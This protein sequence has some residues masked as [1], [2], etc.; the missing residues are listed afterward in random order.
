VARDPHAS[1]KTGTMRSFLP[2]VVGLTC[3][4]LYAQTSHTIVA[5]DFQFAPDLLTI[6]AGDTVW[7]HLGAGHSFRE[8]TADAWDL[9]VTTPIIGYDIGPFTEY[10]EEH[11]LVITTAPDTLYYLCVPHAD[12]G[13]KGRIIIQEGNMGIQASSMEPAVLFPNPTEGPLSLVPPVPGTVQAVITDAAGRI[14]EVP[15]SR[16]GRLDVGELPSGSYQVS[17]IDADGVELTRRTI[18]VRH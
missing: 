12:M 8:V 4:G 17:F 3:S 16:D 11:Y 7:L 2:F 1:V 18:A 6:N 13:M 15:V 5:S 14:V 9:N 10:N